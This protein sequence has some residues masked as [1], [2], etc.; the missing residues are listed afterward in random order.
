M[1]KAPAV[2]AIKKKVERDIYGAGSIGVFTELDRESLARRPKPGLEEHSGLEKL[3]ATSLDKECS[4]SIKEM[5]P[6]TSQTELNPVTQSSTFLHQLTRHS[7]QRNL[8]AGR[9]VHAQIIR[10]GASSC[11]NHANGLVNLYAKCGHLP[12]AHSIFS[13]IISKDVVSWNSLITGYSQHGGLSSSRAVMQLFREM[14]AQDV[15]PNA[16]TLAGIFKAESSLGSCTVGRQAHALVVKMS[17]FGDIY[18]DTSMLGMYC[19]AGLV[20]DGLKVFAF[21]PERNT[22]TWSTMVSGFATRGRVEEAI[23]V[24]SLFLREKDEESD[25]DYVFTAVL[26]SLAATEYVGLGRQ[27]HCITVK[28][29]LLVFVALSNAL[30]TMYSKCESLTEACKMFDSSDD[31]NSITWSAMVTGYSQN[32]ESVEAVKLFSR[33][34]SAG[35]KPSEYTIVGVL[36]A[37]S[38]ICYV[39]EGKQ[40]H[41]FLLKLGFENHLFATTALVDMYAKAGCL[42]DARKGFNCLQERDVALWT[43]II[44]GY[45]QNSDN[46]EALL[47]YCGMKTEGIIPNEPTMASVLKACSSLATLELG[48]QVHGHTIKHGF[49]LEVPIGS[50]LY[51]ACKMFDSSDDRNS[52]TWS[53]MVTGYSQNGESVEAVKLFSR[54]FSAGIKPSEYTIVGVLNACSDI[55]YVEEGKQLHSFLLKLGFENHLFATT[56]LVD[57]YAKAGC[58]EDARKG[59]NCLQERDVALWTS[60]ISGYVQNSD[61]EEALLLYCGMKTEGIIPNEPTMAS[62]LKACSSLATLELGKQ[63]HGHTIKHGFSLEVPIG[64][65]LST[66][67]SK[68]GSLEDGSLV[69]QRTPNKDVVSWNAMISGL[70]HNGRGEE[71]LELFEEMLAVGTEPD[72]VTFVNVISACSH[73]GFVE[74]GWS[75]F[76]KMSDQFGIVPKVDHYACMVDLLSRAGQLK[77]AKE[78]IESASIDHGICLW[79]ILLSACKNHGSCELGAYAGEKLMALGSR[80]SSTY[81]LLSSIYTALGRMRDVERVWGL[82]RANGVSKDVGCSWITVEKQCHTFVVGDTMHPRVEEIKVLVNFVSRRMMEEGFTTMLDSSYVEEGTQLVLS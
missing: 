35:I 70:S 57:M 49:S 76:N 82:M 21:M 46:E 53:A 45:V 58:L 62:V 34:F 24:F 43:S 78:F 27:I 47:L 33:M 10:T 36:N 4:T 15:L 63:V 42:E 3:P 9:A 64:S 75:Y 26:S 60:I 23:K 7:Q 81:V 72:D 6:T 1:I 74:R 2:K 13:A 14:R 44:S 59:F 61:N 32:G 55:C 37:C 20:E 52:I 19:K 56:A 28:N 11:T 48:K 71:A 66:M 73:K 40:L 18:V 29:G 31:R 25:C 80:E 8:M 22:Y 30:V 50:A 12:K 41:S 68:C 69:F 38:D 5:H 77:E 39:E 54:M 79:R 51:N 17:S 67:Y 65:A 16:Y